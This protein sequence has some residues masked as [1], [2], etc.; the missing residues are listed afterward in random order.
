MK[1]TKSNSDQTKAQ[2]RNCKW[3][4]DEFGHWQRAEGKSK[5]TKQKGQ[6]AGDNCAVPCDERSNG[7]QECNKEN[8]WGERGGPKQPNNQRDCDSNPAKDVNGTI[9][10]EK[11]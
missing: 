10:H 7:Q 8:S 6:E 2:P 1:G 5:H 11:S 4:F 9:T 3:P